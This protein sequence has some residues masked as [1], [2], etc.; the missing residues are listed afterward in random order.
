MSP[1]RRSATA[2]SSVRL[3]RLLIGSFALTIA[4][5]VSATLLSAY[6]SHGIQTA[7]H[8]IATN[9]LPSVACYSRT[10]T[11][12]RQVEMMLERLTGAQTTC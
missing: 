4:S 3:M 6:R 8:S 7:A 10:R 9:A 1:P 12:I 11:N 2:Q 5:F